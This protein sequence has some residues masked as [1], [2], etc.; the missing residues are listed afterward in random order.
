[1]IHES[2]CQLFIIKQKSHQKGISCLDPVKDAMFEINPLSFTKKLIILT[3]D[4]ID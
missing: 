1:M 3:N 4:F 2:S